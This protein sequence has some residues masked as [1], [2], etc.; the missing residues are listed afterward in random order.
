MV[1]LRVTIL[2]TFLL[3]Y[4]FIQLKTSF[5]YSKE[6]YVS[7]SSQKRQ[8]RN[9]S[10]DTRISHQLSSSKINKRDIFECGLKLYVFPQI[11]VFTVK[12]IALVLLSSRL[13]N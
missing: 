5:Q 1:T 3:R 11:P 12:L 9:M 13:L 10:P 6:Y 7:A 8:I 4:P 2:V